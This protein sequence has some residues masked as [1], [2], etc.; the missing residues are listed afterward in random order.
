MSV[1][2]IDFETRSRADLKKVG[3]FRYAFDP[4]TEILC[5]AIAKDDE[6]PLIWVPDNG[7]ELTAG[8]A[9][10][11]TRAEL[12]FQEISNDPT[13]LIYAHNGAGF[14]YPIAEALWQ[15]T[16]GLPPPRPEQW[17]CTMAM[18]R[19]AGLPAS[20]DKCSQALGLT[21]K[22]DPRGMA[23]IRKFCVPQK[24]GAK[25]RKLAAEDAGLTIYEYEKALKDT[26]LDEQF[27]NPE[28]EPTAFKE[29]CDY[30]VQDVIV[31]QAIHR[32]LKAFE[33]K[34]INLRM[35]Q[36]TMNINMR[37][38]PVN[39]DALRKADKIIDEETDRL[40]AEFF[41]LTGF[42]PTQRDRVFEWF[43]ANGF[44]GE[45]LRAET[46]EDF[47][48][49]EEFDESTDLGKALMIKKRTSYASVKK[50]K[51]M[52]I[53]AGPQDN[54]VRG[55]LNDYGA[56]T[57][58]L[59]ASL[60]QPQ[61]C[62]KPSKHLEKY[63]EAI[64]RDIIDGA[65]AAYLSLVYGPPLEC[66]SSSIRHFIHDADPSYGERP[67]LDADYSAIESRIASWQAGEEW[68]LEVFRTHGKIYEATAC[69]MYGMEMEEFDSYKKL[70][71]SHHPF[72][73]K[74]KQGELSC[75][76]QGSVGA[77]VRMGALR[78][79]I[80]KKELP[81]IVEAWREISPKAVELWGNAQNAAKSAIQYP[82]Q[83]YEFGVGA[84]FFCAQTAGI[85]FLFMRLPS[86]RKIAYPHPKLE[87]QLRWS[88]VDRKMEEEVRHTILNP[89]PQDVEKAHRQ[90]EK[91]R[92]AYPKMKIN[93]ARVSE[94]ITYWG[95]IPMKTVWGRISMYG[96]SIFNN[97]C[98]GTAA[99]LLSEGVHRLIERGYEPCSL[100]HDQVFSHHLPGQTLDEYVSLLTQMPAWAGG[101]PLAAS[102]DVIPFYKKG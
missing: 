7:T 21:E 3:A 14:E 43:K 10:S 22:K 34:G 15:K 67:F 17:R 70:N 35:F 83:R 12:M 94:A 58:R 85:N 36:S 86:G 5:V 26:S 87:K 11:S 79:G 100:V 92:L 90:V 49:S 27:I 55:T 91:A 63:T 64:Y 93:N 38:F 101:L 84:E 60:V 45:N 73:Q 47:F 29:L 69:R 32:K 42:M 97:L 88:T 19:R 48:E 6:K 39:L 82:G 62:K 96:G 59:S 53:C 66:I 50:V 76:Y 74:G 61:N 28:D 20:L 99:D 30:C 23:L 4:S 102:G 80:S 51:S 9:A 71:G 54:R 95:Q 98:Q 1:F 41:K 78:D 18:A 24:K 81:A 31:E 72:R 56:G 57:G 89:T 77:M 37:G 25:A 65:D 44:E 46:L 52:L 68:K 75:T 13:A 16:F 2:S 8:F 33:L 40:S